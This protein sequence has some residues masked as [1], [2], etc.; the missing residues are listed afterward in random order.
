VRGGEVLR[1][2]SDTSLVGE[3]LRGQDPEAERDHRLA[4]HLASAAQASI[5]LLV[6]LDEVVEEPDGSAAEEQEQEQP[7]AG[8]GPTAD[9]H[10][11]D[12][13]GR[14]GA[15]QDHQPTH[16]RR[17]PLDVVC[18]GAVVPDRLAEAVPREPADGQSGPEQGAD[19]RQP[20]AEQDRP[21]VVEPLSA[22]GMVDRR[23][24]D[25][26]ARTLCGMSVSSS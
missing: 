7:G 19:H 6:D 21:H 5:V 9:Q 11:G 13:V 20:A 1:R 16:G 12:E 17:A 8:A 4:D 2:R 22:L 24:Q 14:S 23:R 18:R 25:A 3:E 15:H 26:R 10:R